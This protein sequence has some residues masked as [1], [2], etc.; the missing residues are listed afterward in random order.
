MSLCVFKFRAVQERVLILSIG[1]DEIEIDQRGS[2]LPKD[3]VAQSDISVHKA[4][5]ALEKGVF[6][7]SARLIHS[8]VTSS[9]QRDN[10]PE[11]KSCV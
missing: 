10:E 11:W 3:H 1:A 5:S 4:Q 2:V 6:Q 9:H 8:I 7:G